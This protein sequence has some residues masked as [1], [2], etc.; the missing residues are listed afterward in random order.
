MRRSVLL[1]LGVCAALVTAPAQA[2]G[3]RAALRA[4]ATL[5][6]GQRLSSPNSEPPRGKSDRSSR[7]EREERE[8]TEPARE[9]REKENSSIVK[10]SLS[11]D[12][13]TVIRH[14]VQ[15][16]DT[17]SGIAARYGT[18][19]AA[20]C[21][22]N[23]LSKDRS[24]R[25]GQVLT[26]PG[27]AKRV[28]KSWHPYAKPAKRKGHLDV[29]T[30]I[31]RFSGPILE[32]D[33]RLRSSAVRT[34]NNLLGA[35]GTH[36]ALPERL[37]RLLI[38]VSDTFAG[39][40]IRLVSGYRTNS[41]YQDSRHKLSSAIDFL[42]VGVPNAVL[43]DYLREFE[44]VGV[45][46][47]P[48]SSFVHLDVRNHSAYWVDYAGPGEPPRSTPNAPPVARE[49]DRKLLAE[50]D[51]LLKQTHRAIGRARPSDDDSSVAPQP[52]RESPAE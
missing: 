15:S 52:E 34:L 27:V 28:Q 32:S 20:L 11:A 43:C 8:E 19:V 22:S 38:E 4:R 1:P 12:S 48:N 37:I 7:E 29:S 3:K 21:A 35:G 13:S 41:Y 6:V 46:Y 26:V 5:K 50:L 30:P 14:R 40:P 2:T 31:S 16:G 24:L 25:V 9:P 17:L 45:G 10:T 23:D 49:T 47:Y 39:R 42:V 18:N 36:P 44:N 33:G 51:G